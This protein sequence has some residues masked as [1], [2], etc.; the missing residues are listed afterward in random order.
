MVAGIFE[1]LQA[2]ADPGALTRSRQK[3]MQ[4]QKA[5]LSGDIQGET[6]NEIITFFTD[7]RYFECKRVKEVAS[8]VE[9]PLASCQ[10]VWPTV[11][12]PVVGF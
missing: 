11:H 1:K 7:A 12:T 2:T 10:V 9:G 3:T 5:A 6:F 4:V 8:L